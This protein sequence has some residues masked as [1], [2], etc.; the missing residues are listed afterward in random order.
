[1]RNVSKLSVHST[2]LTYL[3]CKEK[4]TDTFWRR[5]VIN[6]HVYNIDCIL[7]SCLN[8]S[9]T[10]QCSRLQ[11]SRVLCLLSETSK[12][13]YLAF[14]LRHKD[15]NAPLMYVCL[16][17]PKERYVCLLSFITDP[18][19]KISTYLLQGLVLGPFQKL[20]NLHSA[21]QF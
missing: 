10:Q 3:P 2:Q 14:H 6:N 19:I 11:S 9:S 15:S 21:R 4:V 18:I 17:P 20:T 12:A 7:L 16:F 1:M 5:I 8:N 13:H